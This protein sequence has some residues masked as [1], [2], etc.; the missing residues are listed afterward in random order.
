MRVN[1]PIHLDTIKCIL[2]D[3]DDTLYP[4]NSG[5]WVQ[6]RNRIE[7][8]MREELHF[9]GEDLTATRDRLW[10]TYGTTLRGLQTEYQVD[11]DTYL[12]YVHKVPLDGFISPE[13]KL[14]QIL[15][16]LPQPKFIFTNSD[17]RHARR[18]LSLLDI[19]DYFD[20]VIDIYALAPYCK[21]QTEAFQIALETVG[22]SPEDCLFIDD[23]PANLSMAQQLG[24]TTISVG[25]NMHDGS[26]H[27]QNILDLPDLLL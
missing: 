13:P 27:I 20:Q 17:Y 12:E 21:P 14:N 8:F 4:H 24:M 23:S 19:S 15:D 18:V 3:L 11:M 5:L 10:H 2:F 22:E 6:I 16:N 7:Q 25:Q 1:Q 9:T 26:P